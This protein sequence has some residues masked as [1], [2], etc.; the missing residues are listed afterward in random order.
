MIKNFIIASQI[1]EIITLLIGEKNKLGQSYMAKSY[2]I[3]TCNWE[4]LVL[5]TFKNTLSTK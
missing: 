3:V 5:T 1:D 2:R 4:N